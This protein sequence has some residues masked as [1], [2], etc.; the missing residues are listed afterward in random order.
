VAE[1]QSKKHLVSRDLKRR[2]ANSLAPLLHKNSRVYAAGSNNG[3]V[4]DLIK[5]S[6][7][8][9][10]VQEALGSYT[11]GPSGPFDTKMASGSE[12]WL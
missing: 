7:G 6:D 8:F 11:F 5:A 1:E 9:Q 10:S 4:A 12:W 2:T 3:A